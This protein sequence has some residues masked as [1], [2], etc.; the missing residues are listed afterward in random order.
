MLQLN[1]KPNHEQ[2]V[3][4]DKGEP[5]AMTSTTAHVSNET[6]NVLLGTA[7]VEVF[8][9]NGEKTYARALLDSG[10]TNHFICSEL[11]NNLKLNKHKTNHI[12]Y[13]IGNS[14]QNVTAT[15]SLRI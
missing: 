7:V 2:V 10:S 11:V 9:L 3:N 4:T 6:D 8:G 13:G 12:V 15:V 14:K 5:A 1:Q